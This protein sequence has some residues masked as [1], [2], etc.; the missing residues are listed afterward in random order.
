MSE[1]L[2]I[3]LLL[4]IAWIWRDS[5]QAHEKAVAAGMRACQQLNAQF[6]D[7]T[8]ALSKIRL[9]RTNSGTM[10]LCRLYVFDFTLDG[11]ARRE[12]LISMKGQ[13]IV[14]LVLDIDHTIALH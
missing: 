5:M 8:V 7:Q 13:R 10:A 6:L 1:L 9:C 12:G 3:A 14:D 4:F 2:L 11:E